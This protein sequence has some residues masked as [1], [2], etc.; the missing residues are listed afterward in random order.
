MATGIRD[1]VIQKIISVLSAS[2]LVTKYVGSG[3]NARIY[4]SHVSLITDAVFP[5][6]SIAIIPGG[7]RSADNAFEH[8]IVL[9]IEPWFSAVGAD[10]YTW[11][12]VLEC[13]AGIVD[14][15]HCVKLTDTSIGIKVIQINQTQKGGMIID[16]FGLMHIPSRWKVLAR[17]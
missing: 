17:T 15:L 2:D 10:G 9:Q 7:S 13:Y 16:P 1:R 11:D 8:E 6:V 4:G 5:A 14:A 12:D 3:S